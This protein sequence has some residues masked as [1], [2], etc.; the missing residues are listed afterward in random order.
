ME[1]AIASKGWAK[2]ICQ[3][4]DYYIEGKDI[5]GRNKSLKLCDT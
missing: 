5:K 3:E 1:M 2:K 4:G